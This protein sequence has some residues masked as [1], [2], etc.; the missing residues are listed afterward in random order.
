MEKVISKSSNNITPIVICL[1]IGIA[2]IVVDQSILP[3]WL[4]FIFFAISVILFL[5]IRTITITPYEVNARRVLQKTGKTIKKEDIA[6][7]GQSIK[8][9]TLAQNSGM[10][11]KNAL[12][13]IKG[14]NKTDI[15]YLSQM[16]E[17]KYPEL[18][19]ILAEHYGHLFEKPPVIHSWSS[20]EKNEV[21]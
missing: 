12:L 2:L 4:A 3:W 6:S 17:A 19:R 10:M 1:G 18:Y 9:N 16:G 5:S 20:G 8:G 14:K 15:I 13:E 7:I 11:P 21:Q